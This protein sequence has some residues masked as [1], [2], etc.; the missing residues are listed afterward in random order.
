MVIFHSYVSLPEGKQFEIQNWWLNPNFLSGFVIRI[1]HIQG[2]VSQMSKL[3]PK[4]MPHFLTEFGFG[5]SPFQETTSLGYDR[6]IPVAPCAILWRTPQ[7][8]PLRNAWIS[9]CEDV[10]RS[11]GLIPGGLYSHFKYIQHHRAGF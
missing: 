9:T 5:G 1:V 7:I 8:V 3:G 6:K 10:A 2:D 4:T 11:E